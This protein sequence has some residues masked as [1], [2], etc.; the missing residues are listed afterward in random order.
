MAVARQIESG[1]AAP[2][3]TFG[4]GG[5]LGVLVVST[6]NQSPKAQ[7]R[8]EHGLASAGR[9]RSASAGCVDTE[10]VPGLPTAVAAVRSG[11]L[12]DGV[13]CGTGAAAAGI[14]AGDVITAVAGHS[15]SSPD[16]LTAVVNTYPPGTVIR[17][18]WVSP[19]GTTRTSMIPLQTAPAV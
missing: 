4:V 13:L 11:A 10:S 14:V 1:R 7:A 3:I 6:T 5:F 2:G 15:V 19:E 12:V 17:V 8:E 9:S 16:Q 18:T